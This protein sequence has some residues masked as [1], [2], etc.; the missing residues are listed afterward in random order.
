MEFAGLLAVKSE[1]VSGATDV[2]VDG[3]VAEV[4]AK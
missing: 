4:V 3:A 2:V 1:Y